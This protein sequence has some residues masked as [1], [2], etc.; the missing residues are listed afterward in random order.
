LQTGGL[1]T[2]DGTHDEGEASEHFLARGVLAGGFS[3]DTGFSASLGM[4]VGVRDF[5]GGLDIP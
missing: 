2:G 1:E 5:W 4:L 3:G